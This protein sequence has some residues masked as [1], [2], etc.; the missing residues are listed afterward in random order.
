MATI[1]NLVTQGSVMPDNLRSDTVRASLEYKNQ[2]KKAGDIYVGTGTKITNNEDGV[3]KEIYV[4]EG[5]N[6]QTALNEDIFRANGKSNVNLSSSTLGAQSQYNVLIGSG[7][8]INGSSK[9]VVI[10]C[11]ARISSPFDNSIAIGNNSN[12]N[13]SGI[14]IGDSTL[15]TGANGVVIGDE[16]QNASTKG[17]A[18]GYKAKAN[19]LNSGAIAIGDTAVSTAENAVQIGTGT[20]SVANTLKFRDTQIVDGDGNVNATKINGV[21]STDIFE[22]DKKT[23]KNATNATNATNVTGAIGGRDINSIFVGE[24]AIVK[25]AENL[26]MTVGDP[27]TPVYFTRGVPGKCATKYYFGRGWDSN[28]NQIRIPYSDIVQYDDGKKWLLITL[29]TVSNKITIVASSVLNN[30]EDIKVVQGTVNQHLLS[31]SYQT[32]RSFN[33]V[34]VA[35][36]TYTIS[37]DSQG[38]LIKGPNDKQNGYYKYTFPY[39]MV[40]FIKDSWQYPST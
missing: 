26:T 16:A 5:K 37:V 15:T 7:A 14:A 12:V 17:I 30:I 33:I 19:T 2:L 22:S 35:N 3:S 4:T 36:Q 8:S 9:N 32:T 20:N 29:P 40:Q 24:T 1:D 23:V 31:Q 34:G 13:Y 25:N 38:V 10:G 6:I 18:I 39:V 11:G 21:L 28:N 27:Y